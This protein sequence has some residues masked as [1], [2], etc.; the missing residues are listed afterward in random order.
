[1]NADLI[2]KLEA[3]V[4]LL[5][6]RNQDRCAEDNGI[7]WNGRDQG[8][9]HS[10]AHQVGQWSSGQIKAAWRMLQTYRRTQLAHLDIP[11]FTED[12]QS[13][14]VIADVVEARDRAKVAAFETQEGWGLK[15]TGPKQVTLA[16][17]TFNVWSA[18]IPQGHPF[19]TVWK[20][21]K[22]DLMA[23]GYSVRQYNGWQVSRWE[24]AEVEARPKPAEVPYSIQPLARPEG[25]LPYQGPSVQGLVASIRSFGAAL[26]ASD[27]G[28]GKT[29][30]SLAAFRELGISP[31]VVAPLTVLP[32][33]ERAAKHLGVTIRAVNWDKVR[34]GNTP[35]GKWDSPAK[36]SFVWAKDIDGLIFDEVHRAKSHK[37]Q[38]HHLVVGGK[39]QNIPTIALSATAA[40]NPLQMKALGYILGLH[41][42]KGFW[43]WVEQYGCFANRWG[44]YEFD[45]NTKHLQA[46]HAQ[47]FPKKG[48]RVR[49]ADLGDAF[50]ETQVATE[51]V[52]VAKPELINRAFEDVAEALAAI[53]DKKLHDP[54]HHLTKLLRARQTSELAKIPALIQMAEDAIEQGMSVAIFVNF[55]ESLNAVSEHLGKEN[56][57]VQIHG[58]QTPEERQAAIDAF[59]SDKARVIVANI[60]A[61]GVGVSLHDLNGNHPRMALISPTW[62]AIDLRQALGR[63]HRAGGK[64]KSLQRIVFAAGTVEERVARMVEEKLAHLDTLN[65]GE[66]SAV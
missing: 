35:L 20:R 51:L 3:G 60:K 36:K 61:G 27:V 56:T 66:L 14:R 24:K 22:V 38:N 11:E 16:K 34:T 4:Q 1:M 9:G 29:Y 23:K 30:T 28:T 47:I 65:D 19:W 33:W 37:T 50:P 17:G 43:A 2:A 15:W 42:Y 46:L 59:Q 7:G 63:V 45:G 8:L 54:E 49:V 5:T 64:T 44:G 13:S 21:S 32:S 40:S 55:D 39:R 58:K 26:D 62:S 57:V 25:L 6:Q 12:E 41:G 10:L 48:V 31:V 18:P 53:A 52:T